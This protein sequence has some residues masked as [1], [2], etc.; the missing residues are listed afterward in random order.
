MQLKAFHYL[1]IGGVATS[2]TMVS[3]LLKIWFSL[4]V[5]RL[6]SIVAPIL[7][8]APGYGQQTFA[9]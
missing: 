6:D 4:L 9:G 8:Q 2:F 7:S 1:G 5:F 3:M